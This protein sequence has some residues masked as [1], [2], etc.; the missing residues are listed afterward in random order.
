M[1]LTRHNGRAGKNGM[2]N[3]KHNDRRFDVD[4]SEHIDN[5]RTAQNIY[6]DCY[7]GITRQS[8]RDPDDKTDYS[9]EEIER[10]FYTERY[11]NFTM[12]QHERNVKTRHTER[13]R[14]P[15]D[16]LLNSKTCPEESIYQLGNIEES[17]SPETLLTVVNDFF[18]KMQNRFGEHVHVLDWALH[19]DEATPHIQE[20]H[21]FDCENKYGEIAPQQEKALEALGVPLPFPDQKP[22]KNNNRKKTFDAMCRDMLFE[23]CE[24]HGIYP[25]R[26]PV[27]GGREH[28]EKQDFI[29]QK[30]NEQI[31]AQGQEII[32][33]QETLDELRLKIDDIEELTEDVA[34]VAYKKAVEVVTDTVRAETQK[35]DLEVIV[36]VQNWV[37]APERKYTKP[38]KAVISRVLDMVQNA[39]K[40]AAKKMLSVIHKALLSP[41]IKEVNKAPVKQAARESIIAKLKQTPE[42]RQAEN[43]RLQQTQKRKI[44]Q[45]R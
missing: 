45:E 21:V 36:D 17:V 35:A 4:N 26:E 11:L 15:H 7:R 33:R 44:E 2:F 42:Q 30:Q 1:K 34:E 8:D 14:S 29:I 38:E 6:W 5:E 43:N 37:V 16:L 39:M 31:V 20:R 13:D 18:I 27:S 9:F 22:G 32:Q 40:K 10:M 24:R 25:D 3:P 28:Q 23:I 12:A 41:E 19:L